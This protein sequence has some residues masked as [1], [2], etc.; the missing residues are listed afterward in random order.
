V[1][2]NASDILPG[3]LAAGRPGWPPF[4]VRPIGLSLVGRARGAA[5]LACGR[6][7]IPQTLN[8][9]WFQAIRRRPRSS[10]KRFSAPPCNARLGRH[11]VAHIRDVESHIWLKL[12]GY[13]AG[14][15]SRW[16]RGVGV[17]GGIE[18]PLIAIDLGEAKNATK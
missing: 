5:Y 18:S 12:R 15:M 13:V 6:S 9:E 2:F 14:S 4:E 7:M 8:N 16:G 1:E 17:A 11:E 3:D 10:C